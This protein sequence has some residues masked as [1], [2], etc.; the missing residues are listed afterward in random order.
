MDSLKSVEPQM[1]NLSLVDTEAMSLES[2]PTEIIHRIASYCE[3]K[4]IHNLT[5][6]SQALNTSCSNP[7]VFQAQFC[8]HAP[9]PETEAVRDHFALAPLINAAITTIY[10]AKAPNQPR[11]EART[12]WSHLAVVAPRLPDLSDELDELMLPYR[13]VSFQPAGGLKFPT[14]EFLQK[15]RSLV[16]TFSTFAVLG[17]KVI[18]SF[19]SPSLII[20]ANEETDIPAIDLGVAAAIPGLLIALTEPHNWSIHVYSET[21]MDLLVRQQAFCLALGL[22]QTQV[23]NNMGVMTYHLSMMATWDKEDTAFFKFKQS[24]EGRQTI[25]ML[26]Q[27]VLAHLLRSSIPGRPVSTYLPSPR[28]L[29]FATWHGTGE[30]VLALPNPAL[31]DTVQRR[32][33]AFSSS[34]AW[35]RWN[36][37]Y[38][39]H[40]ADKLEEGEWYGYFTWDTA[41]SETTFLETGPIENI[42]FK[43]G[44]KKSPKQTVDDN[45]LLVRADGCKEPAGTFTFDGEFHKESQSIV[46]RKIHPDGIEYN[47][48]GWFTPLGIAGTLD[49]SPWGMP[50]WFW[51][52]KKEWMSEAES[53]L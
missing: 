28:K 9:N 48:R 43:L 17:C 8:R 5:S 44:D 20:F 50:G 51:L 49:P 23:L 12:I 26:A 16:G 2:L 14:A 53:S 52:W 6:V 31:P 10:P 47:F 18:V 4:D 33:S 3:V 25:A 41:R 40:L 34:D 24:W 15:T 42:H 35:H 30:V 45:V 36:R 11:P 38:V 37:A 29:P 7:Y 13:A 1:E 46:L 32:I 27:A 22:M 21:G 39:R 19:W